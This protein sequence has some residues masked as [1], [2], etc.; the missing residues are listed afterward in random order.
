MFIDIITGLKKV[1]H[2]TIMQNKHD[3]IKLFTKYTITMKTQL[4]QFIPLYL[5]IAG[6][7]LTLLYY[8]IPVVVNLIKMIP[9]KRVLN[10]SLR[11][12]LVLSCIYVISCSVYNK[13]IKSTKFEQFQ[14]C[15]KDQGDLG[16]DSCYYKIYGYYINPFTGEK[17][18]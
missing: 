4:I 5:F 2:I 15:S 12:Y 6:C 16:C 9:V 8:F 14:E 13:D 7:L 10:I 1:N 11:G 18:N 3:K 17:I